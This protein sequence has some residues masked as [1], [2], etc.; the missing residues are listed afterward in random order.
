MWQM[1]TNRALVIF[2]P[3]LGTLLASTPKH[4]KP[5]ALSVHLGKVALIENALTVK[6]SFAPLFMVPV[7]LTIVTANLDIAVDILRRSL[8]RESLSPAH[9]DSLTILQ[10]L[11]D[12][13]KFLHD[14]LNQAQKDY[15]HRLVKSR[16]KRGLINALGRVSQYLFG[17]AMD[18]DV[19]D[20]KE[21]YNRLLP[22]AAANRKVV[23][24][25]L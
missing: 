19:R 10:L 1:F 20:L 2:L 24:L 25:S 22:F 23:N 15:N 16:T 5:G 3:I 18:D 21:Q 4:L 13:T 12:R 8:E 9:N 6:Y 17:M 14:K 11:T 7:Q